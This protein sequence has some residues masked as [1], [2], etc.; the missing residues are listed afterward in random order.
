ML[1]FLIFFSGAFIGF[2]FG[3]LPNINTDD[4]DQ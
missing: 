2:M 4:I 3:S 1:E